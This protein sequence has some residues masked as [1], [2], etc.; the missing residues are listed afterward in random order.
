[1][2]MWCEEAGG[3]IDI[4]FRHKN[5]KAPITATNDSNPFWMAFKSAIDEL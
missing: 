5:P 4:K 2:N 1:M 3:D